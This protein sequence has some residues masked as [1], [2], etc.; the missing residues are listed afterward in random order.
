MPLGVFLEWIFHMEFLQSSTFIDYLKQVQNKTRDETAHKSFSM[1]T[2]V[3]RAYR[4]RR[5]S[6]GT[7]PNV[8]HVEL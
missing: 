6:L 7:K 2:S 4:G 5:T 3:F 8:P 1:S